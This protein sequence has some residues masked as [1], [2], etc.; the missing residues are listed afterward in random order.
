MIVNFFR[1]VS[2]DLSGRIDQILAAEKMKDENIARRRAEYAQEVKRFRENHPPA[3]GGLGQS[4]AAHG[5]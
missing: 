2:D 5:D 1:R 4:G 3:T